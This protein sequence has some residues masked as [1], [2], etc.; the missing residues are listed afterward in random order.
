M[1]NERCR[2]ISES[3][4]REYLECVQKMHQLE[5]QLDVATKALKKYQKAI[6]EF[7]KDPMNNLVMLS[8]QVIYDIYMDIQKVLKEME[9]A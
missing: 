8:H 1:P 5:K 9:E 2:L 4:W 3:Q 7:K 6:N